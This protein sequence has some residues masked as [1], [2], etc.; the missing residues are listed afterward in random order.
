MCCISISHCSIGDE[1]LPVGKMG[2]ELNRYSNSQQQ[3]DYR[4]RVQIDIPVIHDTQEIDQDENQRA[5]KVQR[6]TQICE[7][8]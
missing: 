4:D 1:F 7:E 5:N 3:V 2:S 8:E 6:N